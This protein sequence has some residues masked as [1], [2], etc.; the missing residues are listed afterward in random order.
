M[1]II[2]KGYHIHRIPYMIPV[3]LLIP[4]IIFLMPFAVLYEN[5]DK[6]FDSYMWWVNEHVD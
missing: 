6:L 4:L 2:Y 5:I 3:L 1:K